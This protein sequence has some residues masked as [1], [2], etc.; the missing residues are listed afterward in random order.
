M[1]QMTS[2][3][4]IPLVRL[5]DNDPQLLK[6]VARL[7]GAAGLRT[8]ASTSPQEFLS[9]YDASVPGCLVLD[10]AMPEGSGLDLQRSLIERQVDLP[11]VFLSGHADVAASVRAMKDGA[12]DFLTKPVDADDLLLA[13]DHALELDRSRRAQLREEQALQDRLATLTP[14]EREVLPYLVSGKLNKQIAAELGV[15]EKT[16][17]V[18]R[19]RV[20]EKL[21]VHCLADL[22]RLAA[23][24]RVGP[25]AN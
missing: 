4:P 2:A 20:M 11:I 3:P 18:H 7:L 6:A 8:Q 21:G 16:I 15:V 12:L 23:R 13:V 17:K 25:T 24:L 5:V 10:L 19:A 9:H 1:T 14:R 22:V